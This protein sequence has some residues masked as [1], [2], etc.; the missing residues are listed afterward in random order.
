MRFL[1]AAVVIS[2]AAPAFAQS[3]AHSQVQEKVKYPTLTKM[4]KRFAAEA[5]AREAAHTI[6]RR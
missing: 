6:A 4:I 2:L 1:V 3:R 5:R